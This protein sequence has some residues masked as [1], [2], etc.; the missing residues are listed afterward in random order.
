MPRTSGCGCEKNCEI[1][2]SKVLL[3]FGTPCVLYICTILIFVCIMLC[4]LY[5]ITAEVGSR[6][7]KNNILLWYLGTTIVCTITIMFNISTKMLFF[8]SL[9]LLQLLFRILAHSRGCVC[10]C[11]E[12]ERNCARAYVCACARERKTLRRSS[13]SQMC[14]RKI[15]IA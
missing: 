13:G 12:R 14:V 15:H 4:S 8:S 3:L 5:T 11:A 7:N 9:F 6:Y 2:Q 1:C 10:V